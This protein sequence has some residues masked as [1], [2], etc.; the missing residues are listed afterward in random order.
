MS[1]LL[2]N[3]QTATGRAAAEYLAQND[4][5]NLVDSVRRLSCPGIEP[6]ARAY[7]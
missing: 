6:F 7:D 5:R 2:F 4:C 3:Y 1:S